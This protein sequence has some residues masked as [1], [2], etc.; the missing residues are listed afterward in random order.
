MKARAF[1][2]ARGGSKGVPRK[3]VKLLNG[4]PLIGHA[5][6]V[7]CACPSLGEVIV[8]TDDDEIATIA[9][10]LGARVPFRRPVEL[11]TD[12]AS[13]WLAWRHAIEWSQ[14]HDGAFETFVSLPATSPFR[15]VDDVERCIDMLRTDPA[16]DV[17]TTVKKADRSPYFNMVALKED[18]AADLVM[19]PVTGVTRRQDAPV[20]YDM[21]TVAYAARPSFVLNR[22]G[23]F[24]GRMRV[25]EVPAER[26]LDIDTAFDFTM[27]EHIARTFHSPGAQPT[28]S[29]QDQQCG[30]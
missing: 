19:R 26:A 29:K 7:A 14:A 6:N 10:E 8:S 1:I 2:F 25:V 11:A 13:E 21:T 30:Q 24:D 4:I 28:V 16:A 27:A 23:L 18:G 12:T 17:V 3:N 9:R 5:I 15:S 20:V 22:N